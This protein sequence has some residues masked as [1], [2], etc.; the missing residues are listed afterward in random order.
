VRPLIAA[1][2]RDDHRH[3]IDHWLRQVIL[4]SCRDPNDQRGPGFSGLL[5]ADGVLCDG[6]C[7][8]VVGTGTGAGAGV[9]VTL[10]VRTDGGVAAGRGGNGEAAVGPTVD[11]RPANASTA[12]AASHPLLLHIPPVSLS[13]AKG[14]GNALEDS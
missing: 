8:T 12:S 2:T 10:T 4:F 14:R 9:A 5:A 11:E 13:C 6:C 1:I 3:P 7:A